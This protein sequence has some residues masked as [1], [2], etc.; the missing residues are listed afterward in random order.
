MDCL[1]YLGRSD[2]SPSP[3]KYF[4]SLLGQ[5]RRGQWTTH[6]QS[7]SKKKGALKVCAKQTGNL[8]HNTVCVLNPCNRHRLCRYRATPR[9]GNCPRRA[10]G[11]SIKFRVSYKN[12]TPQRTSVF[13]AL[14]SFQEKIMPVIAWLL[15]VPITVILLLMLFGVF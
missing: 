10:T 13:C 1:D 8:R 2:G 7:G 3:G 4:S 11:P 14:S 15:G 5:S 12:E 6:W 9:H